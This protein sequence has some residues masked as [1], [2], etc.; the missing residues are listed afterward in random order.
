MPRLRYKQ[1]G[2]EDELVWDFR[3]FGIPDRHQPAARP[4][5]HLKHLRHPSAMKG[6]GRY[7]IERVVGLADGLLG[8]VEA[9]GTVRSM[10]RRRH[11]ARKAAI[12]AN[13]PGLGRAEHL[14]NDTW[15]A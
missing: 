15:V 6:R 12:A 10:R 2:S 13:R 11:A 7:V 5:D 9:G 14:V 3:D 1:L 8:T 4:G